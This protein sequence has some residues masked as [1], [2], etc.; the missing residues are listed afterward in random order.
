MKDETLPLACSCGAEMVSIIAHD[1][2][3]QHGY[4]RGWFCFTCKRWVEAVHR[5]RIIIKGHKL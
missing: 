3:D 5:E 4:R 1:T 2:P